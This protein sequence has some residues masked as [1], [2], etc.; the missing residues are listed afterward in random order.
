LIYI[1]F[2]SSASLLVQTVKNLPEKQE[3]QVLPW[4][5]KIFWRREWQSTPVFSPGEFHGQRS[6]V[7][8]S[9]W[10]CKES[11]MTERLTLPAF[12]F[13]IICMYW[14]SQVSYR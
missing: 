6:L 7:G 3:T 10:G 12:T 9:P 5:G 14:A 1:Y 8:Y 4:V 2:L 13:I 11:D